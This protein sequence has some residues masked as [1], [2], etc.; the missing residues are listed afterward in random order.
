MGKEVIHVASRAEPE[1]LMWGRR[2]KL[3]TFWGVINF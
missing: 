1:I 3:K 2:A